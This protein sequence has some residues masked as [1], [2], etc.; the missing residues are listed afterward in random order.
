MLLRNGIL[1][2]LLLFFWVWMFY[3]T[4]PATGENT[5]QCCETILDVEIDLAHHRGKDK[6]YLISQNHRYKLD[7]GWRNENKSY[8]LAETILSSNQNCTITVWEHLPSH[9]DIIYMIRGK[10]IQV[11]Q[12]TDL[13]SGEDVYW[14][15]ADHNSFQRSERI[16]GIFGGIFLSAVA[17]AWI[18]LDFMVFYSGRSRKRKKNKKK[19]EKK[20]P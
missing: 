9:L 3:T 12:V 20:V 13:R 15:I 17:I 11:Y 4:Q 19:T 10:S 18:C 6:L 5:Y 7:T 2:V 8:E 1:I 16:A 14:D